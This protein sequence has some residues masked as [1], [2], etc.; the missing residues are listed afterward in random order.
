[1]KKTLLTTACIIT[2]SIPSTAHAQ[3]FLDRLDSAVSKVENTISRTENTVN[4]ATGTAERLNNKIPESG[5]P[6]ATTN[7]AAPAPVS[8]SNITAEEER[9]LQRAEEIEEKRILKEAERIKQRQASQVAPAAPAPEQ[10]YSARRR[11]RFGQ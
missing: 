2:A 7:T 11:A 9:I 4:R 8:N 3:S 5:T 1:M 6:A 10:D